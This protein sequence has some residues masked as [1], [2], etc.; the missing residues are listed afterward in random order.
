MIKM[1]HVSDI[2]KFTVPDCIKFD[3]ITVL[4]T[5][6]ECYGAK[7][8]IDSDMGGFVVI[9]SNSEQ[10]TVPYLDLN[11]DTYEYTEVIVDYTKSLYIS[12][13]ERNIVVY[14]KSD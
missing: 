11:S 12:G 2:D 8:D 13:S 9:C 4:T 14:R 5:L 3:V 1:G 7:R 10:L 6:D